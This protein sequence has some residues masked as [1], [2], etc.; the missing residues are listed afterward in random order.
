MKSAS[1]SVQ[2]LSEVASRLVCPPCRDATARRAG[3]RLRPSRNDKEVLQ[4]L[5][6]QPAKPKQNFRERNTPAMNDEKTVP[7]CLPANAIENIVRALSDAV[8]ELRR[9]TE[10]G[11][12]SEG[13]YNV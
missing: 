2:G 8:D 3:V 4:K 1:P 11:P 10:V 9:R 13:H 5:F 7:M 12:T 6:R